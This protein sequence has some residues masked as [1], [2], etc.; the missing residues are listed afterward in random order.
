MSGYRACKI[1]ACKTYGLAD[2]GQQVLHEVVGSHR[3]VVGCEVL[4]VLVALLGE[5]CPA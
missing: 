1:L 4:D 5:I 3:M 2:Q